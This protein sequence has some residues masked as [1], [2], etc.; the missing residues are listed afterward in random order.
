MTADGEPVFRLRSQ[1][2]GVDVYD[3]P[4]YGDVPVD[5]PPA[6]F[7]PGGGVEP[8]LAGAQPVAE[9]PT[10]YWSG[11]W[12]DVTEHDRLLVRG[13]TYEVVGPPQSWSPGRLSAGGLVVTLRKAG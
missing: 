9:A 13:G 11:L 5:L 8:V 6:L 4:V 2:T 3:N 7:A 10:L 12:P 1:K